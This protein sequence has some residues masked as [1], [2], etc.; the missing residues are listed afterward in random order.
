MITDVF[1]NHCEPRRI[2]VDERFAFYERRQEVG[3]TIA[4]YDAVKHKHCKFGGFL[5]QAMRDASVFGLRDQKFQQLLGIEDL[6]YYK[7]QDLAMVNE[8]AAK[9]SKE[10]QSGSN[11]PQPTVQLVQKQKATSTP[12]QGQQL[13]ERCYHCGRK[14]KAAECNFKEAVGHFCKK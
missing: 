10:M 8:A 6:S 1:L 5:P 3:E 13:T 4:K 12:P 14:H 7:A 9:K 2:K 11:T